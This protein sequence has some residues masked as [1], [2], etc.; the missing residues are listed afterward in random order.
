MKARIL[1]LYARQRERGTAKARQRQLLGTISWSERRGLVWALRNRGLERELRRAIRARIHGNR[2]F[3]A[4]AVR[5]GNRV[6]GL[7][8][9]AVRGEMP[10]VLRCL[11]AD[12]TLWRRAHAH[13]RITAVYQEGERL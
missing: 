13:Q 3:V 4:V 5:T 7:Q 2:Y 6:A 11:F 10:E 8:C 12:E 9:E 1:Y